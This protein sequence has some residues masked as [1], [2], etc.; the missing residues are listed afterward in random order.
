LLQSIVEDSRKAQLRLIVAKDRFNNLDVDISSLEVRI[1]ALSADLENKKGI[2][3]AAKDE[4]DEMNTRIA[5]NLEKKNGLCIRC[6]DYKALSL[7]LSFFGKSENTY[8]VCKYWKACIDDVLE[9]QKVIV[10]K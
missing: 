8:L 4:V 6:L 1:L 3:R 2:L 9:K 10:V 7:V 5:Y